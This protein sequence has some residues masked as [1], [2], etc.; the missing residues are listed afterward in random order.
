M[1][2]PARTFAGVS[3][4]DRMTAMRAMKRMMVAML[5]AGVAACA[6]GGSVVPQEQAAQ[7]AQRGA[8]YPYNSFY[9]P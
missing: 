6:A 1:N 2:A 3:L 9:C 5:L 8:P 4:N 7:Y